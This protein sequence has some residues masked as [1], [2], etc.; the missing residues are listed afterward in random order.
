VCAGDI[1]MWFPDVEMPEWLPSSYDCMPARLA[2]VWCIVNANLRG[3]ATHKLVH[4]AT[5]SILVSR[6]GVCFCCVCMH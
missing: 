5:C 1:V 2:I 3:P 4:A 6:Q